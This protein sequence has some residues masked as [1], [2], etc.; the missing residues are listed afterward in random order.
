MGFRCLN[1]LPLTKFFWTGKLFRES[2]SCATNHRLSDDGT[3]LDS[4]QESDW[5]RGAKLQRFL[6]GTSEW[7]YLSFR[8]T[9]RLPFSGTQYLQWGGNCWSCHTVTLLRV[10]LLCPHVTVSLMSPTDPA[11]FLMSRDV[12]C[13]GLLLI[14]AVVWVIS[15]RRKLYSITVKS[16][17][18]VRFIHLMWLQSMIRAT[19][20]LHSINKQRGIQFLLSVQSRISWIKV[21]MNG[22]FVRGIWIYPGQR[23]HFLRMYQIYFRIA[24]PPLRLWL[25]LPRG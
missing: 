11:L 23:V 3:G 25:W 9:C 8:V 14:F 2:A 22:F 16:C 6:S 10:T 18:S 17:N 1:E 19:M 5:A 7:V 24:E 13:P 12:T 20:T 21:R 4:R 15:Q